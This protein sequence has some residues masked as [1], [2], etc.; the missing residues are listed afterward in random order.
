MVDPRPDLVQDTE[1]WEVVLTAAV[2]DPDLY[3]F[4]HGLRCGGARL[5]QRPTGALKINYKP[6]LGIWEEDVLLKEWL[7][8]RRTRIARLFRQVK[9]ATRN[10]TVAG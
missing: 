8:P 10:E 2:E 4:L 9:E 5:M 7:M 1:L 3:W 6:L